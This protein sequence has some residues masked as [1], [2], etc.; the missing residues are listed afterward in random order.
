MLFCEDCR[1]FIH[2]LERCLLVPIV[3]RDIAVIEAGLEVR[4]ISAKNDGSGFGQPNEQ[5]LVA[6]RV[7]RCRKQYE[8]SVVED[9]VVAV[10]KLDRMLLVKGDS[11]LP[12]PGPFVLHALHQHQRVRKHFD[13]SGVVRMAV[14]DCD[15][16]Y[17]RG[18]HM[19][20]FE[21]G[22]QRYWFAP[23]RASARPPLVQ[24][25]LM[26]RQLCYSIINTRIP[27]EPPLGVVN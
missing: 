21:L 2:G 12:A 14:G 8:A 22:R 3:G 25:E 10:D 9:I 18:L 23:D 13:V 16:L 24:H 27:Q 11:I 7:S 26:I 6:R 17:I 4:S 19:Y 20:L 1:Y 15:Q 5:R